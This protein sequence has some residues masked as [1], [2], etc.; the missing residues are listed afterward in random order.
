VR[1]PN[2]IFSDTRPGSQSESTLIVENVNTNTAAW[3]L[4]PRG[5]AQLKVTFAFV[6]R[7]SLRCCCC[8]HSILLLLTAQLQHNA[9]YK[10]VTGAFR[11][12]RASGALAGR[13]YVPLAVSFSPS[14]HG[15]YAQEWDLRFNDNVSEDWGSQRK[16]TGTNPHTHTLS[17]SFS[18]AY[19][20]N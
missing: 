6:L 5:S 4:T 11:F 14:E 7:Q 13:K 19:T 15:Q 17:F 8:L 20:H 12:H 1:Q 16:G 10:P 3:T 2:V 18:L 9:G